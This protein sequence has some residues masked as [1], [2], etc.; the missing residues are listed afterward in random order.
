MALS[1]AAASSDVVAVRAAPLGTVLP[2]G[3]ILERNGWVPNNSH[4]PILYYKRAITPFGSDPASLF[5]AA[6]RQ[7]AWPPQWRNGVYDSTT[8]IRPPMRC[9]A[10]PVGGPA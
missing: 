8:T 4:L 3:F 9:W 2:Q 7:N 1:V 6:F 5:E 10:S